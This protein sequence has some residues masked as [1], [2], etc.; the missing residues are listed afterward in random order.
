[1]SE[2]VPS[3]N[4]RI[5]TFVLAGLAVFLLTIIFVIDVNV[6]LGIAVGAMYSIVIFY[7]WV[8]PKPFTPLTMGTICSLLILFVFVTSDKSLDVSHI[9]G[10]NRRRE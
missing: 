2:I 7:S 1:M 4:D 9:A 5:Q 3:A 8:L 6:R 10:I